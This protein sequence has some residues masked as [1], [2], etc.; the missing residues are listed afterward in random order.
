[1]AKREEEQ[2]IQLLQYGKAVLLGGI[3]A[4][5]CSITF[6]FLISFLI[7]EGKINTSL[8]YQLSVIV[9]VL[10]SLI[11]GVVA[12]QRNR[13]K[14]FI[15]GFSVGIVLF[16]LQLTFGL[17]CYDSFTLENGE[18]GLLCGALCGGAAA[19]ILSSGRRKK[20]SHKRGRRKN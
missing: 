9:T 15:V 8:Q 5:L 14:R 2:R 20:S 17:L 6:L 13:D 4:F 1:M 16:L 3:L 10:G 19:G 11:G 12:V 18:I 7:S